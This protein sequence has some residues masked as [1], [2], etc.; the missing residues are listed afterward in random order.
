[1]T[2]TNTTGLNKYFKHASFTFN[3]K[4][5]LN[6]SFHP[7]GLLLTIRFEIFIIKN[8]NYTSIIIER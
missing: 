5:A 4:F 6:V 3:S 1:M 2:T 7:I 8:G